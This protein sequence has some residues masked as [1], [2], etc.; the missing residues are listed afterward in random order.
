MTPRCLVIVMCVAGCGS[1]SAPDPGPDAGGGSGSGSGS[2]NPPLPGAVTYTGHVDMTPEVTFGGGAPPPV[3][4]YTMS[5]HDLRIELAIR[6]SGEVV[7]GRV[8]NVNV[9][10]LV[11]PCMYSPNGP[12]LAG[13]RLQ[14]AVPSSAGVALSFT[15]DPTNQTEVDLA[16]VLS[17]LGTSYTVVL[18]FHRTDLDPPLDWQVVTSVS[19]SASD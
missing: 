10:G 15:G 4:T 13:Y 5:L 12:V 17:G 18:R 8:Q 3:C 9:E 16:G 11:A 7:S 6:P 19:L 14:L 1:V 2:G